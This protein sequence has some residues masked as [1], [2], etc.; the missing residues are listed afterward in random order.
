MGTA[1]GRPFNQ[2]SEQRPDYE[3]PKT[4]V[5]Y[6]A[7][8]QALEAEI[9]Q[10]IGRRSVRDFNHLALRIF[11]H[12]LR[13][14]QPYARY[15]AARG[16]TLNAM[17][18][19]WEAIPPIPALAFKEAAL[20]TFDPKSAALAFETSGTTTGTGGRHY[21]ETPA[22]YDAALIA[23]FGDAMLPDVNEPL[24][25]ALLVPNPAQRPQSSLGYMMRKVADVFGDGN[26]RWYLHGDEL[27]VERFIRD[28]RTAAADA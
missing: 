2:R 26:E 16:V 10:S 13:Y 11:T 4:A 15:C 25:Y 7:E 24:R 17:P 19:D 20:C 28:V 6:R 22:L 18:S 1:L 23:G 9:L 12:Q 5:T 3:P 27:D 8:A 14:N 21:M